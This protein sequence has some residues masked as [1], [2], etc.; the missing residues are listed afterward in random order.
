VTLTSSGDEGK[1]YLSKMAT[2]VFQRSKAFER[3]RPPNNRR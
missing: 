1:Q 2:A 3:I